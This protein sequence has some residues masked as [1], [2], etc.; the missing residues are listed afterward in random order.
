MGTLYQKLLREFQKLTSQKT[1]TA[2]GQSM[3]KFIVSICTLIRVMFASRTISQ[4]QF[5]IG[6]QRH[7]TTLRCLNCGNYD[8]ESICNKYGNY[9]SQYSS[10]SIFNNYSEYGSKFSTNSPWNKY[11]TSD[12]V[13][14]LVDEYGNFYGYFTINNYRGNAV[15]FSRELKE[16]FDRVNGDLEIIQ[17]ILC[18]N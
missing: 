1:T 9:G 5:L 4:K 13:P 3:R 18:R 17:K 16:L 11:S 15:N 14:V 7:N 12:S 2:E 10:S 8:S 6:D